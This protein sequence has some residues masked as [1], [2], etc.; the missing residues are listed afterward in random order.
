VGFTPKGPIDHPLGS[1]TPD[2]FEALVYLLARDEFP[3]AV[4]I[5]AKDHGLDARTLDAGGATLRGWQAKRFTAAINWGQCQESMR[6]AVAFWRPLRVTFAFPKI[7]S[8]N[9]QKN[10]R[11]RLIEEFPRIQIDW[12]GLEELQTR[13][14]D[15]VPDRSRFGDA[16]TDPAGA[17]G[18]QTP[19]RLLRPG[20]GPQQ[21]GG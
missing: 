4:R 10:F 1:L 19:S 8:G 18:S 5:R 11:G 2:Q 20:T 6:R 16:R 7:L 12:W 17:V 9:E 15:R 21:P 3:G 14:R 13:I